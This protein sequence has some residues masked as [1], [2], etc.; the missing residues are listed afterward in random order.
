MVLLPAAI[1]NDN[2][3]MT[4]EKELQDLVG[5]AVHLVIT[6]KDKSIVSRHFNQLVKSGLLDGTYTVGDYPNN[7]SWFKPESVCDINWD[8]AGIAFIEIVI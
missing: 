8:D 6:N 1:E 7:F 5:D 2:K 3:I 4:I